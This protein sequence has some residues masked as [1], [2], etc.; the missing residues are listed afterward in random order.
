[1]ISRRGKTNIQAPNDGARQGTAQRTTAG[2]RTKPIART[3]PAPTETSEYSS[4][5]LSGRHP[6]V[7]F[8][9]PSTGLVVSAAGVGG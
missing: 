5:Y 6:K 4:A 7:G 8:Q 9:V 3:G 1:M 2:Q